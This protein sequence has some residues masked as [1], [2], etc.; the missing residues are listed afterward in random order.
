MT[1]GGDDMMAVHIPA[2]REH[3]IRFIVNTNSAKP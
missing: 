2:S 1:W 3:L